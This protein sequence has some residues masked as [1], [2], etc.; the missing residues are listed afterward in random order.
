MPPGSISRGVKV[1]I[2]QRGL[3]IQAHCY[4]IAKAWAELDVRQQKNTAWSLY[5]MQFYSSMKE[6]KIMPFI[7][8]WVE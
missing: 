7:V 1:N 4:T 3:H 2:S 6:S 8:K 5:T